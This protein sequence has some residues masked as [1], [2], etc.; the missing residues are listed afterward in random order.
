MQFLLEQQAR[1]DARQVE[2]MLATLSCLRVKPSSLGGK[3]SSRKA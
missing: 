1:F 3:L 2:L